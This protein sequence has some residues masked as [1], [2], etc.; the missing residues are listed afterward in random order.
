MVYVERI[1]REHDMGKELKQ[2]MVSFIGGMT[3]FAAFPTGNFRQVKTV[4][5]RQRQGIGRHFSKTGIH[6]RKACEREGVPVNG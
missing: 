6:L 5:R 1:K 4:R 2:M 3:A